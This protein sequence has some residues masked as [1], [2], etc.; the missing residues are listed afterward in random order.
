ML[1]F[2]DTAKD[3][4]KAFLEMQKSQGV[5][6]LRIVGNRS[7]HKLFLVKESERQQNDNLFTVDD[8]FDVYLDPLSA[9]NLEGCTVDFVESVMKSGF[10]V[11]YPSPKWDD[12][13][14][15][16]V[17]DI[18]DTEINPGI[19]SHGGSVTLNSVKDNTAYITLNGG[20]QGCGSADITL[21]HGIERMITSGA[22]E[23]T[24]I[25][26]TT[27]HASGENPYYAP[28]DAAESPLA[29]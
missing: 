27:D 12:P 7:E 3:R 6:A 9:Q 4:I 1:T 24:R 26:D 29:K 11:F 25:V 2:T 16:K 17:Q 19:A 10:R 22:P 5:S 13:L 18:I 23:I 14:A 8:S 28:T 20:C 21:K 15:Q